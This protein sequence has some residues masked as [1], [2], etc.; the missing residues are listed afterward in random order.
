VKAILHWVLEW[1][2]LKLARLVR[3]AYLKHQRKKEIEKEA[4]DN[5]EKLKKA[6]T[7]EEKREALDE[8]ADSLDN[9]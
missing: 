3:D 7:E 1:V 6:K 2:F 9:Q 8:I 4:K 5:A